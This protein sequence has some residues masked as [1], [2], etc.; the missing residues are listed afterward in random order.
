M[1]QLH[2][3][4]IPTDEVARILAIADRHRVSHPT[5]LE[6][7]PPHGEPRATILLHLPNDTL[8]AFLDDVCRHAGELSFTFQPV[9]AIP[10]DPP[11]S[12]I[13]QQV[14]DVSALST[15]EL[16]LS[17]LQ[18]IGSWKGMVLYSLFSGVVAAYGVIFNVSYLLVAAMLINPMG[19]PAIVTVIGLAV[20]DVRMFG[21]G[22]AR[23]LVSL[24]LQAAAAAA[25]G[26]AYRLDFSTETMEQVTALSAM[27]ALLALVAGAAGAQSQIR[28][29][30]DS[31]VSGS[32][33]GF[34]VAAALAPPAA[35][36]G[37]AL[38]IGR[39][40][41]AG[42]M[43]FLLLL[44]LVGIA[45]GGW[46]TLLGFGVAPGNPAVPRGSRRGRAVLATVVMTVL[47]AAI[48]WQIRQ[49]PRFLKADLSRDAVRLARQ[50]VDRVQE[51]GVVEAS[52]RF[53]R[54]ELRRHEGEG[55]LVQLVVERQAG[56]VAGDAEVAERVRSTVEE[57]IRSAMPGVVPFVDVT[58]L[59]PAR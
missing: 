57:R 31:L 52:A 27:A 29:E 6:T 18:S 24:V 56:S 30:R 33:A 12:E 10:I 2:L 35:V 11:L 37:L 4:D 3:H 36:L 47:A 51:A 40:D 32:A 26:T 59:P 44:Q 41:Y 45:A 48:A 7:R 25:L 17:S 46:L 5:V 39:W 19:A 9:G 42:L 23:F 21:R 20:G 34:M 43:A 8:G 58:V 1:R 38:P 49:E 16:V 54:S 28:S 22:A 50:G 15:L 55:L 53:T 14:R 13:Q